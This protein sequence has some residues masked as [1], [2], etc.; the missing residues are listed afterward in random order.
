MD[1]LCP[2]RITKQQSMCSITVLVFLLSII[3]KSTAGSDKESL[4]PAFPESNSEISHDWRADSTK[5]LL[6]Q[7]Q[8]LYTSLRDKQKRTSSARKRYHNDN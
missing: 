1:N 2:G 8:R 6:L 3:V 5:Q 7:K 4:S